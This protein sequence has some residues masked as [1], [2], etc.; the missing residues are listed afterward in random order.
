MSYAARRLLFWSPRILC[1]GYSIFLSLF[2]LDVFNENHGFTRIALALTV[3]LIPTAIV[4]AVLIAA[5][6]WEWI[7][8][9]LFTLVAAIYSAQVLPRHPS[10]AATIA[11]PLFVIAA[12]FL[13]N[14]IKRSDLRPAH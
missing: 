9:A 13:V 4:V 11:L 7:G 14:W 2:A 6:R 12:L 5:W 8:A 10:W 1:I 3:H